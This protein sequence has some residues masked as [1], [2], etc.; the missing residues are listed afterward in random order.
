MEILG[1]GWLWGCVLLLTAGLL[2]WFAARLWWWL[3]LGPSLL[4]AMGVFSEVSIAASAICW[5]VFIVG[6]AVLG[7]PAL[8]TRLLSQRM[9]ALMRQEMPPISA[10]EHAA[11]EAGDTGWEAELFSGR[12]S[13]RRMRR[14]RSPKLSGPER[15]FL[16]GPVEAFCGMISDYLINEVD[17]DL[18]PQAWDFLKSERFFGMVI[19]E[20]YGGLGFSQSGHAAV[21]MKIASRS[22]SAAL[23]AMIPNSVGPAKLILNYG[24]QAQRERYLPALA[25]GEEIPCFALT[26]PEAGSDASSMVD[27]GIVCRQSHEGVPDV[28]GVRLNFDKRYITLAPVASLLGVAFKLYDPDQLLGDQERRGITLALVPANAPGVTRGGRHNTLNMG[29]HNGPVSGEDVFVPLESIIGEQDGIGN[30]WKMLM[31]CLT[32]GRAISLPSLA[33]GAAKAAV[34]ITGAYSRVRFQFRMPV[35][36]FE[37]VQE[38]L[39]PMAGDVWA[40]DC[41]RQLILAELDGGRQPAVAA[42][43]VKYNLTERCRRVLERAMDIH[44]GAGICLGPRNLIAEFSK[45]PPMGVTVEGANILTRTLM[46]FGQGVMRCHPCLQAELEAAN[47]TGGG[48]IRAFDRVLARHLRLASRH[49]LRTLL[50]GLSG[51]RLAGHPAKSKAPRSYYQQIGRLSAGFA[52][53]TDVLLLTLRGQFK[54]RERLSGRMADVLSNLYIASAA[55]R[56]HELADGDASDELLLDWVMADSLHRCQDSLEAVCANLPPVIGRMLRWMLFPWGRPWPP[57]GDRLEQCLVE[58]ITVP[59]TGR[60]RIAAGIYIP[61]DRDEQLAKLEA[62]LGKVTMT[63]PLA[64]KLRE[65]TRRHLVPEAPFE[66]RLEMAVR[67]RV[68]TQAEADEL[69]YAEKSRREVLRVDAFKDVE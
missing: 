63:A 39:A 48:D 53:T 5:V 57:P 31:E 38:A 62:A 68:L 18:P 12:P 11:L 10:T 65:G 27:S 3:L 55:L 9:M 56:H 42:G 54:R 6:I 32:D 14:L 34:R 36:N 22:V 47:R 61:T 50:L 1:A 13:W 29:F 46:T 41:A 40:M 17:R 21:V 26:G 60:D 66:Q 35:S 19:P 45:F 24:T 49:V 25:A 15:A 67:A 16:E 69:R 23:T 2:V 33:C 20:Q 7:L 64:S 43:I 52:L 37:G 28:L 8:R 59:S 4:I 30:G 58:L 51:A 44:A